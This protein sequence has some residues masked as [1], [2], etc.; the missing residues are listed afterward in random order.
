MEIAS[1]DEPYR[2]VDDNDHEN[3]GEGIVTDNKDDNLDR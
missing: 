1:E 2:E 3:K